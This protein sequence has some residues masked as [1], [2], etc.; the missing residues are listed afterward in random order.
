MTAA[1]LVVNADDLGVSRGATLGI[2][3]AHREGLVTSASLAMTM[4]A[5]E[6]ALDA[7]VRQCP[8]LGIGL[9][10]TLTSGRPV[11]QA[12]DVPKLVNADGFFRWRFMALLRAASFRAR[13]DLLDQIDIE[14]EAQI[15]RLVRDGV[16]PDHID[17]ERH[18]HLIPG[19]IERVMAAARRHGI[20]FIR[21]GRETATPYIR[22]GDVGALLLR[23]GFAKS[24]LLSTLTRRNRRLLGNGVRSADH[25]ASY[26][27]SGRLDLVLG[28]I[29]MRP[30]SDG[31]TEIMV[32]PGIPE[33]SRGLS[34]D[35]RELA[36]YLG[37]EDRRREMEACI[38]ARAS[39]GAWRLTTFARLAQERAQ[40]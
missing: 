11:S 12:R 24:W 17:G 16:K 15:Q 34:F 9:H 8:D 35:N 29:L 31:I 40:P 10:F 2:V 7:C 37:S 39:V 26:L 38:A 4:P 23:G 14:L 28:E 13:G 1:P 32:H 6:H 20:P 36:R 5:Y 21:L 27:Y 33:E 19:I 25:F 18:V 30:P 3:R 22:P